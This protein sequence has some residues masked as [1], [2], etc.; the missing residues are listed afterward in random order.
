MVLGM[1]RSGT[2]ALSRVLAACGADPGARLVGESAGNETG[3]WEDAFAVEL[4]ER[5]LA[6]YGA[7]WDAPLG[8]PGDWEAGQPARE[9][10]AQIRAYVA[11]NREAHALWAV[12][13][14]RLC[15][16]APLW[17]EAVPAAGSALGAVLVARHPLE[18]AASLAA[19]DGIGE[20]RALLL[21]LEY[22]LAAIAAAEALPHAVVGY[23]ALLDDWKATIGKLRS[24]PGGEH[25][26]VDAASAR[27]VGT[28]LDRGM[29]HHRVTHERRMP[30]VIEEAWQRVSSCLR[31]GAIPP[32]T[33]AAM[34]AEFAPA[35]ELLR[36]LAAESRVAE[37]RLWERV[38]RAE[39][40]LGEVLAGERSVPED[41]GAL[42]DAVAKQH[43]ALIDAFSGDVARMQQVAAQAMQAA[44]AREGEAELARA[45]EPR[46]HALEQRLGPLAESVTLGQS[47]LA[48]S[49]SRQQSAL[50][51]AISVEL[52]RMQQVTADA[53][54]QAGIDR[55]ATEG[56]KR[57]AL[58]AEAERQR[59]EEE[60]R[61]TQG[62]IAMLQGEAKVAQGR[63][64]M[65]QGEANVA[66]GRISALQDEANVAQG[67][68]SALQDEANV[69]QGRISALQDEAKAA[70]ER[71]ETLERDA[72]ALRARL[73]EADALHARMADEAEVAEAQFRSLSWETARLREQAATLA[74]IQGS[75]SWRWTRPFRFALRVLS[76][77]SG[78]DDGRE[79]RRRLKSIGIR[80]APG[81]TPAQAKAPAIAAAPRAASS[82]APVL[83][84]PAETGLPDVFVW[85]V[86]DWHFRTQRPQHLAQAL[87]RRGH[88]VFYV[89]NNFNDAA[90]PGFRADPLDASGR[91]FQVHLNLAGSPPIYFGLPDAAQS[92]AIQASLAE[93]LRWTGTDAATSLV[94]HPYWSPFVRMVP[95][96]RVVYDCMDHHA[97]F[98]NNAP[99]VIRAEHDLLADADLV[100]V[101]SSWLE[102]EIAPRARA[103]ALIR[104]AGDAAFFAE[105][106]E[107][108]F[109][110]PQ[111]RQVIGYFGAIAEWFDLDLVRKVASANPGKLVLLIGSDTAGAAEALSGLDNVQLTGEV[112]YARLP[113]WLHGFDVALLP[114]RVVDLT[115]A[116]NPVKVYEYLAAG[117][118]VV[119]VD[120]PEMA[121]F[122]GLVR[123]ARDHEDFV[124][125]V[126]AAL[127]APASAEDA[128]ARRLFAEGQTWA[129]RALELDNALATIEEPLVTVV[130]LTY[131][132][133]DFSRNC[134]FSVEHYSDYA[135]L[136]VI[137]VDNASSDGSVEW[138]QAWEQE[139]SRAGHRRRL[140]LNDANLGFAAGNNVG[141]RAA[142]GDYL[143]MLNNDTYVTRGWV[144]T[145]CAHLRRDPALGIVGPATNNIGN[146]AKLEIAYDDIVAM[147]RVAGEY[148]R[149]HPGREIALRTAAFFCVAMPRQVYERVGDL[150]EAFGVG[151]FEDDDYCRR[152]EL[153]GWRIAC[154]EDVFV[155]H[156]LSASFDQLKAEAKKKLFEANKAIYEA[157][158]G[159]WEPH[160][161]RQHA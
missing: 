60:T 120:V 117:K 85:A 150:D 37:R 107:E 30:R 18:V 58:R 93:L 96:A 116:T 122:D 148:T 145:L 7:S 10:A 26:R 48:D 97:G 141:L 91:L 44:A 28:F 54:R 39:A 5:L 81:G 20:G 25:L 154:A 46:L 100:I 109:R 89:S 77:R 19:R 42:R 47:A 86:I 50:I 92:A 98:E 135:N 133:L 101:T 144:R 103:T 3:H 63:I 34:E 55:E 62:R 160:A 102:Q 6:S 29:R 112:P 11:G 158:W 134:L 43:Q 36:P 23:D 137:V 147:H 121:Q 52:R 38:G 56:A 4:H 149:A 70:Q 143:V 80:V 71:I 8:L 113:Y 126:A 79:F 142:T 153:A 51:E 64:A 159:A 59:A 129:H 15:L 156:H 32:G 128:A 108:V 88:R 27:D 106:P 138:L 87:A 33:A 146:E 13:D 61:V 140:I 22:T 131:N 157:K 76:G 49:M 82:P 151:F 94:Q 68:I 111:G 12:K 161:Y 31:T 119:A 65:L 105:A 53:V 75:R 123:V 125:A 90:Q 17:S 57:D 69:A 40:V 83:L 66:Q 73:S 118:P 104:N 110:D 84:K 14:P 16:F 2:S 35:R 114:F 136:E 130:V 155:H 99:A 67:R 21:W 72:Q 132:N 139:P 124:A 41:I 127:D 78:P 115:M 1:H 9:A 24:L 152:V 95:N 74:Q 45:L